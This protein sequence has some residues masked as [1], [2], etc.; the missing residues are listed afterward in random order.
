MA[1]NLISARGFTSWIS[2]SESLP[3]AN[4]CAIMKQSESV[5]TKL[6]E[7]EEAQHKGGSLRKELEAK[8]NYP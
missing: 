4:R 2:D 7:K 1:I 8:C 3:V 6:C 5:V